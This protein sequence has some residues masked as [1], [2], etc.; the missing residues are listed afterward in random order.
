M[1]GE[2]IEGC[3]VLAESLRSQGVQYVF[4]IVGIPVIELGVALQGVGVHYIGMRNEQAVSCVASAALGL[5]CAMPIQLARRLHVNCVEED[6][7]G[8]ALSIIGCTSV[9]LPY[10]Q[11]PLYPG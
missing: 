11:Q 1:E 2:L 3:E 6:W 8:K 5:W 10:Y 7:S 9:D 4:G